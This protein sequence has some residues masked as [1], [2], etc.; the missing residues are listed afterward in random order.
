VRE[1]IFRAGEKSLLC[2]PFISNRWP[3]L[4]YACQ[5]FMLADRVHY[6][7]QISGRIGLYD[8]IVSH[9]NTNCHVV[10]RAPARAEQD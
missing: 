3:I 8:V 1:T 5:K 9:Q 4:T 2:A 6:F 7:Q 10:F